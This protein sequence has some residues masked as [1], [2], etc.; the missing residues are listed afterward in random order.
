MRNGVIDKRILNEQ[1]FN[2]YGSILDIFDGKLDIVQLIVCIINL[3]N[4][5][6]GY[7]Q[8]S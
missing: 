8:E 5:N 6:G 7:I 3:I 1:P 4:R 2:N